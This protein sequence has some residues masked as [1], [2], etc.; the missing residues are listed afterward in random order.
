M[1]AKQIISA[2]TITNPPSNAL[3][4]LAIIPDGNRRWA[5]Q[6][7]LAIQEGH[8]KGFIEVSPQ[9]LQ[10]AWDKG[11][12]TITLWMFSSENW[13]RSVAEVENLMLV[14]GGFLKAILPRALKDRIRMLHMGRLDRI[15]KDLLA[16][17]EQ[18]QQLTCKMDQHIFNFALDYSGR[19]EIIRAAK[20]LMHSPVE[21]E[22]IDEAYMHRLMNP[23]QQPYPDPDLIIRT[24]GEIRLSGFMPFQS[25]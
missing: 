7:N 2:Q 4:H 13:N 23:H 25:C 18:V 20:A 10:A 12:H 6:H 17:V 22:S 15:P 19:D 14:F 1:Y 3:R 11:I 8:S 21:P 9:L 16:I 5:R 24:S